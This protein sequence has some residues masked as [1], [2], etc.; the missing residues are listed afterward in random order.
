MGAVNGEVQAGMRPEP[1]AKSQKADL[2]SRCWGRG[3][4]KSR[5]EDPSRWTKEPGLGAGGAP[6]GLSWLDPPTW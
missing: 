4:Q 5:L 2:S 6:V 3:P 1:R